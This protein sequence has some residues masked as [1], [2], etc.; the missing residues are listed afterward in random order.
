MQALK[1]LAL[2]GGTVTGPD[3]ESPSSKSYATAML[4]RAMRILPLDHPEPM[5][6]TL[7]VMLYPG[8]D[9]ESRRS[10]RAYTAQFLSEPI[11][12]F[13]HAGGTLSHEDLLRIAT[14]PGVP[15]D[16]IDDRWWDGS[17]MGVMFMNYFVLFRTDPRLTS[18]ENAIKLTEVNATKHE[19]PGSRSSLQDI[20]RRYGSVAHLWA[21]WCIRDREFRS[22]PE[23]G[24]EGWHDF[25][26]FLAES[27]ILRHW[28]QNWRRKESRAVPPLAADVWR[29]PD[30]WE[31]PV[32]EPNWPLSGVIPD[33]GFPA[34][35]LSGLRP[36][37]RPLKSSK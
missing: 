14:D 8:L 16:D 21:A 10:A 1:G 19:L 29:V 20:R 30:D 17:C 6:A 31:P 2:R 24:Y 23:V 27:E 36:A 25:Q 3:R 13:T 37:G 18:W 7:G 22:D 9:D 5:A 34:E 35:L 32:R 11:R 28:G 33:I 4:F 26:F 12:R 15:L